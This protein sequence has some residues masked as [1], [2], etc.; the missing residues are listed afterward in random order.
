MTM[1]NNIANKLAKSVRQSK[2]RQDEGPVQTESV[3]DSAL[4]TQQDI[5]QSEAT[6]E[7][8]RFAA[9]RCWPD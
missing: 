3:T 4:P 2:E 8:R 6:Q 9:R 7:I 1:S 5:A